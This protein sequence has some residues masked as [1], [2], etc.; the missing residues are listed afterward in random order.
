ML[1]A[2]F[3]AVKANVKA[4]L[5]TGRTLTGI[6]IETLFRRE[7]ETELQRNIHDA[8]ENAPWSSSVAEAAVP[9]AEA[10]RIA[11]RPD[12]P[13]Q[14]SEADRE[15]L[16]DRGLSADL[17]QIEEYLREFCHEI[18]DEAVRA[19]LAAINAPTTDPVV[20]TARMHLL[21]ARAAAW[22]RTTRVF[23]D[24]VMEAAN[25]LAAL[26]GE[27]Y[28]PPA[29]AI[30]S[31]VPA[32]TALERDC[33]FA[34]YDDRRFG[35]VIEEIL[36]Q[37]KSEGVWKGD[38]T[39]Q[40]RIM[41]TFSWIT[42]NRALGSYDHRD[43]AAFK[44]GLL[45][46][47]KSF[48][49]G[50]PTAGAMARPF[51]DIVA[52]L[53]VV[54]PDQRRNM[55]TVNRDLSTMSTVAK[56][57]AQT[58]WRPRV[59]GATV[60]DFSSATVAIKESDSTGLRPPW[61]TKHLEALFRSPLYLGG[62]GVKRRLKAGEP[63]ARV[64]HDAAYFAPLLWY[65]HHTCREEM[66]GLEVADITIDAPV[67]HFEIRDN[68]TRGRDGDKAGEKRAA[69]RRKLPIHPELIRL[70]FLDY[71]KAVQAEGHQELF[72]ELYLFKAKRGGAQFYDRAWRYMVEWIGDRM[73]L[74]RNDAGK[75]ADIHSIR[76]LGSSFYE[77]D[78]VNEIL[79]A[80]V[81]GHARTG[82]NAKHYSK[83]IQTEGLDVV[84]AERLA[85]IQRY[86]PIITA[87]IRAAPIRLLP[88]DQRSRVGSGRYRRIRSDAGKLRS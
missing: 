69:R 45:R 32:S 39:Q 54:A 47:P 12:H 22:L 19:R 78:G 7:L 15:A 83:R 82:T 40:R 59:S 86:V 2:R 60:M 65:Y 48:R 84:L 52:E 38:L 42:G 14:L 88:L 66:C 6:E 3:V 58:A 41:Q 68:V 62:G 18:G 1:S 30:S 75:I 73:A 35:D 8:Y 61:T 55:K 80:D 43:V 4:M 77:V 24:D 37:L 57:L 71:V 46:L 67:P 51:A 44:Q 56:H 36:A 53:P 23:D 70:G 72:P 17:D 31:P 87:D 29:S 76:A 64:W 25:P 81:M 74:P 20:H 9:L 50:T 63:V 27:D 33:Q 49:F 10:Y 5:E 21:R 13:R 11:R 16:R 34:I 79:R 28:E 26:M 85:F